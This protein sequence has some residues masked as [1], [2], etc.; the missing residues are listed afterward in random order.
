M[1]SFFNYAKNRILYSV[2]RIIFILGIAF[3]ISKCDVYA[4]T[5]PYWGDNTNILRPVMANVYDCGSNSCSD[6]LS[7]DFEI[8]GDIDNGYSQSFYLQA[9][10]TSMSA[11]GTGVM[12]AYQANTNLSATTLYSLTTYI[13]H[14]SNANLVYKGLYGASS[15]SNVTNKSSAV[16][17][18]S[19]SV[20]T[21]LNNVPFSQIGEPFV[22]CGYINVIFKPT[23]NT[24]WLGLNFTLDSSA[25]D[26][27]SSLI[28][29]QVE[30][31]GNADGLSS[32]DIQDV[33]NDSG[34]ASATDIEDLQESVVDIQTSIDTIESSINNNINSAEDSIN[35]NIDEME[36]SING[37]INDN[38]NSKI[39]CENLSSL[40]G[41]IFD[42]TDT[43]FFNKTL[44][45]N[46]KKNTTYTLSFDI[47][48]SLEP[49][50]ISLGYGQNGLFYQDMAGNNSWISNQYNGHKSITFTTGDSTY[51][52]LMLRLPRYGSS[53]SFTGKVS[54]IMLVEG[55]SEK[56]YCSYGSFEEV[57]KI[58]ETN[59][60]LDN[61]NDSINSDSEN[62]EDKSCGMICKLGKIPGKII[63]GFVD[64]LK[65]LFIPDDDYF[66]DW[67]N[68]LKL[69]FEQ[70]LGFL[71]TPFEIIIDFIN[72]FLNLEDTDIIINIPEISVPNFEDF[73]LIESQTFNWSELLNSKESLSTLWTLYLDFI[74][75]FLILNFLNLCMNVY[76]RIIGKNDV[77]YDYYTVE[78]SYSYDTN[79]GEVLSARRNERKTTRKRSD[80]S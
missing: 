34:L 33:I 38:F 21:N 20:L 2:F 29:Y 68:E 11:N 16:N 3:L 26:Y 43:I 4:A 9:T 30:A 59:D 66:T 76:N 32:S 48:T 31:L 8:V 39:Y 65:S 52:D 27:S 54:N 73:V 36:E 80:G 41:Y 69:F 58:D 78:D 10:S 64:G 44:L 13:C 53:S 17:K 70:K 24:K 61:L 60:K 12:W 25:T 22:K 74:D 71:L 42:Y 49:F 57:N 46:F 40:D 77:V 50:V 75:V 72:R 45:K 19:T 51:P 79:T 62:F 5:P 28:G 14:N 15:V 55:S 56:E 67:F 37:T 6:D 63:D 47:S 23:Q 18:F 35:N 7:S 1:K